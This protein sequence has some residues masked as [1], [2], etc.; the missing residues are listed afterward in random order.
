M[1]VEKISDSIREYIDKNDFLKKLMGISEY[2]I[3]IYTVLFLINSFIKL[4]GMVQSILHY[5]FYVIIILAFASKKYM[6]LIVAFLGCAAAKF[7]SFFRLLFISSFQI[8]S[9]D[10]FIGMIF[11]MLLAWAA[12]WMFRE[13]TTL[14]KEN[15]S[16]GGSKE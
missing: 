14:A 6:G 2:I 1:T 7:V 16:Q 11:F 10:G 12:I 8:F 9:W 4:S 5:S 15:D 3:Y 13:Q